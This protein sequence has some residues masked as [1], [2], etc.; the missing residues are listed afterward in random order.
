MAVDVVPIFVA[1][2]TPAAPPAVPICG[3]VRATAPPS[4][5]IFKLVKGVVT[6]IV[7]P[8]VIP[9]PPESIV[10]LSV[11]LLPIIVELK[12]IVPS[13]P[14]VSVSISTDPEII[15][16]PVKV[17]LLPVAFDVV[18]PPDNVIPVELVKAT[19]L[20]PST[21]VTP[22]APTASVPLPAFIVMSSS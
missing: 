6:P 10:K 9:E 17:T 15:T 18:M 1:P 22:I 16:G 14:A 21:S 7:P 13:V 11:P 8:K 5:L 3:I 12:P 4:W 20:I 19:V 2:D